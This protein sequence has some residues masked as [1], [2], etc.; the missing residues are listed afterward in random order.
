VPILHER[1]PI[2]ELFELGAAVVGGF[3]VVKLRN[4]IYL[5]SFMISPQCRQFTKE[6]ILGNNES[7]TYLQIYSLIETK[8]SIVAH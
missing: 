6:K 4:L 1:I 7:I 8:K 5:H 2:S 3:A